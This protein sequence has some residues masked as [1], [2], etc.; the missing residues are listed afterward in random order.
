LREG[1][2]VDEPALQ[3][4]IGERVAKWMI[5]DRVIFVDALPRTGVGK[6]LKREL[7]EQY[8]GLLA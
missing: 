7:R 2:H 8:K 6:F 3:A 5:P 4:W 1:Q